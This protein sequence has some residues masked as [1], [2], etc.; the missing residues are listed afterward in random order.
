MC[1][2][3]T[4]RLDY[5]G[6]RRRGRIKWR[7]LYI[8]DC[9][10]MRQLLQQQQHEYSSYRWI[11]SWEP[12][13]RNSWPKTARN[14]TRK[15]ACNG[16]LGTLYMRCIFG[17]RNSVTPIRSTLQVLSESI[18]IL[19][20]FERN[21]QINMYRYKHRRIIHLRGSWLGKFLLD[22]RVSNM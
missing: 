2:N 12:W 10:V 11:Q 9:N 18:S 5:V 17:A 13:G 19:K 4:V 3:Q 1:S 8:G 6:K 22:L 14:L 21:I 15:I 16:I 20:P 7:Q